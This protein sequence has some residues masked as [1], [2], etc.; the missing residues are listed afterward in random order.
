MKDTNESSASV[1]RYQERILI[2]I[3]ETLQFGIKETLHFT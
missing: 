2:A 3:K 1:V